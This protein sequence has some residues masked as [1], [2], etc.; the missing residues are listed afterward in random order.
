MSENLNEIVTGKEKLAQLE[1]TGQY[2]F[3]GSPHMVEVFE[4][5]QAMQFNRETKENIP[6]GE[7]QYLPRFTMNLQYLRH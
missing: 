4:P 2:V 7:L 1:K 6:D 5:R 3:H